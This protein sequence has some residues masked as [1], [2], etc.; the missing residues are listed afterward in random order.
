LKWLEVSLRVDGELAEAVADVLA[1]YAPNGIAIHVDDLAEASTEGSAPSC[2]TVTA[3]LR[4][5]DETPIRQQRIEEGLWHLSQIQPLPSPSCRVIEEENWSDLWKAKYQPLPIGERLLIVPAWHPVPEGDSLAIILDP[6]MAFG[7]GL[8]PTTR[9]CLRAMEEYLKAGEAVVDLGCGSGILS[10]AAVLLG[11]G[12]VRALD[13]D[14]LAVENTRENLARNEILDRVRVQTGSLPLLLDE[15][16]SDRKADVLVANIYAIVLAE[17]LDSGLT[18]AIRPGG[19]LILSGIMK[20]QV[21]TLQTKCEAYGAKILERRQE[22]D[23]IALILQTPASGRA[24][25]H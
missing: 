21:E 2:V 6:G 24:A 23:W 19:T 16:Q 10:I 18:Q 7:T 25:E 1:R 13:S 15:N 5:D 8:H 14:P 3:Y 12:E 17:L 11:A 22:G 4:V 9:L 20:H